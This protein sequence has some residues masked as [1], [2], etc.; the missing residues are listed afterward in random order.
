MDNREFEATPNDTIDRWG[1]N[2]YISTC[3]H[4]GE[5]ITRLQGEDWI[6]SHTGVAECYAEEA[7]PTDILEDLEDGY[8]IF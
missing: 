1:S 6:H 3:L 4:C 2:M 7:L 5:E 8:E